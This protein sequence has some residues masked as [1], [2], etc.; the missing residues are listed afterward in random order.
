MP[1][2]FLDAYEGEILFILNNAMISF[3]AHLSCLLQYHTYLAM[4][5]LTFDLFN[6]VESVVSIACFG[7]MHARI[8]YYIS[9]YA[10]LN[11]DT[12]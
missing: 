3:Y 6:A 9:F 11:T 4:Y 8:E 7:Y 5:F 2:F 10:F 12:I 1:I